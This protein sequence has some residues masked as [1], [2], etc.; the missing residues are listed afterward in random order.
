M[1][2]IT[3][4][5]E[6][7]EKMKKLF[8]KK[9]SSNEYECYVNLITDTT[10]V[11]FLKTNYPEVWEEYLESQKGHKTIDEIIEVITGGKK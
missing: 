5:P 11:Y 1:N 4:T 9:K 7:K 2:F 10:L 6:Y 8:E 3:D